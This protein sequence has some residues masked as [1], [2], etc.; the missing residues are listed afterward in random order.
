[1]LLEQELYISSRSLF[2]SLVVRLDALEKHPLILDRVIASIV[3]QQGL[4][5]RQAQEC[6]LQSDCASVDSNLTIFGRT[7]QIDTQLFTW[8]RYRTQQI[9]ILD[10][11][12]LLIYTGVVFEEQVR[13]EISSL[14]GQK[15][16]DKLKRF[17]LLYSSLR[18]LDPEARA[19]IL[20]DR[21]RRC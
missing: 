6:L 15:V 9:S 1:M 18:R 13:L 2:F 20:C 14:V 3:D 19:A 5:P 8:N 17:L 11:L 16:Y 12:R 21:Y 10:R 4:A 7:L